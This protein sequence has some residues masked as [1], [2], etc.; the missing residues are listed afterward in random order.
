MAIYTVELERLLNTGFSLGLNSYPVPSYI[1]T[2]EDATKFRENLNKKII[3]HYRFNEICCLPPDRFKHFINTKMNEIM[4][5][6][7]LLYEALNENWKFYTG[8]TLTEIYIGSSSG[9]SNGTSNDT[10]SSTSTTTSNSSIAKTGSDTS[11]NTG[12][13][14]TKRTGSDKSEKSGVDTNSRISNS[15]SSS[16]GYALGV[17]SDTPAQMLNIET[18]IANNTYANTAS[19]NKTTNSARDNSTETVTTTYNSGDTT[20]HNTT[21][22]TSTIEDS[23]INYGNTTITEGNGKS[24]QETTSTGTNS[25]SN[26]SDNKYNRSVTGLNNKS[27]AELFKQYQESIRNIDLEI[28]M[29]LGDCFMSIF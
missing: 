22:E 18:D 16:D 13:S 4:P 5:L 9:T 24:T 25:N 7:N 20:T 15:N 2:E 1:E 28:V 21:D 23:V 11:N 26:S 17:S 6:K 27:Y 8:G 19:K 10:S 3:A 29:E 14:T 12:R